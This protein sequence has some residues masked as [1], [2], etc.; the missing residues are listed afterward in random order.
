M[1][2]LAGQVQ[3]YGVVGRWIEDEKGGLWLCTQGKQVED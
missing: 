3:T 2:I 1:M